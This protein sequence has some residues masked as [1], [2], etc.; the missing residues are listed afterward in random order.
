MTYRLLLLFTVILAIVPAALWA[1]P[2]AWLNNSGGSAC[3][4]TIASAIAPPKGF[5]R[6]I[7]EKGSFA[8]WLQHLPLKTDN[9]VY[10]YNGEKKINQTAQVAVV[11][12]D[13]GNRDLQQCADAVMRLRAE[14]LFAT[15][16]YSAIHFNFTNG[17]KADFQKWSAGYR[18]KIVKGKSVWAQSS[19]VDS[20]YLNFKKYLN[21]VFT[22]AGTASLTKELAA[23]QNLNQIEIGDVFIQG[24]FPGHAV[25][26]LDMAQNAAGEKRFLLGQSYMPAQSFHVL[27]NLNRPELGAWF[28]LTDGLPLITPEWTFRTTDLKR[29][30]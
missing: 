19:S 21:V 25:L 3:S 4:R 14:Y 28:E 9:T 12:I 27:Q 1:Q 30:Q 11:D 8:Q 29:F 5:E 17:D 24:G 26:V 16:R 15:E 2:Y 23:V 10:L 13:I 6:L 18:V 22:Y 7:T 20:T